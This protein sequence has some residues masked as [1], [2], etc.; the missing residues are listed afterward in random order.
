MMKEIFEA[1]GFEVELLEYC[2]EEGKFHYKCWNEEDRRIGRSF[3]F[4]TRN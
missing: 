1:A 3:R 2:D 4:D